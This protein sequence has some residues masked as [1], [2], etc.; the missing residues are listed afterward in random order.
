MRHFKLI[1]FIFILFLIFMTLIYK[2]DF[3]KDLVWNLKNIF[4]PNII[5]QLKKVYI[6]Y[7]H[8]VKS[9]IILKKNSS[10]NFESSLGRN[11]QL[12][13]YQNKIF[14]KNGPK[15]FLKLD[16]DELFLITGTG[17]LSHINIDSFNKVKLN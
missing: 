3:K 1:L 5:F 14:N 17:I 2:V 16:N 12:T 15:V 7:V 9:E 10:I 8:E 13:R 11:F 6:Y 4:H